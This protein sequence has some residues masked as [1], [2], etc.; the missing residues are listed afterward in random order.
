VNRKSKPL[1]FLTIIADFVSVHG[2]AP[3]I[4]GKNIANP[5]LLTDDSDLP[6]RRSAALMLSTLGYV[7]PAA[8]INAAVD[9]VLLEGRYTTPDLGGK[10]STTE[11]I[12]AVLKR[13]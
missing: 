5:I 4:E 9:A 1:T 8:R 10:S 13:L 7:E 6:S 11:V 3:D 2:S 12:E